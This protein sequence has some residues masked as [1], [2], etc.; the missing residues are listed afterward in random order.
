MKVTKVVQFDQVESL[1]SRGWTLVCNVQN[2]RFDVRR[3]LEQQSHSN[4]GSWVPEKY[5]VD[6]AVVTETLFVLEKDE[7]AISHEAQL[8]HDLCELRERLRTKERE[9]TE[10]MKLC[11]EVTHQRDVEKGIR[12]AEERKA[13][14]HRV[15][16]D[17]LEG[18]LAKV[19]RAIGD[20]QWT[21]ITG[22]K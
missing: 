2:Q 4:M 20:Q 17:A 21:A 22:K 1:T 18:D 15:R 5:K 13:A 6:T 9:V 7:E 16:L 8:E 10:V 12:A 11:T 14:D 3:E 19:R